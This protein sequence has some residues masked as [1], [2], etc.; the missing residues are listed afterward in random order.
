MSVDDAVIQNI[1]DEE[2]IMYCDKENPTQ[3]YVEYV[4]N[5]GAVV[6]ESI[7]SPYFR[8][9]LGHRYREETGTREKPEIR[10]E[11]DIRTEELIWSGENK[12]TIHKRVAGNLKN[13]VVYFLANDQ[14]SS[15]IVRPDGWKIGRLKNV[16]FIRQPSDEAQ[17]LPQEGGDLLELMRPYVNMND[18]DY[19][20][21][22]LTLVQ[23]FIRT[24]SHFATIL[25]SGKGTGKSTL[26]KI[27]RSLVDPSKAGVSTP[28][29]NEEALIVNLSNNYFVCYDNTAPLSEKVS[30]LLCA[31]ITGSRTTKRILYTTNDQAILNLHNII[32]LNGIS[33]VPAK[34]DLAERSLLFKLKK[35]KSSDRATD[36]SIW[37]NF[38]RDKPLILGA[39]F[40]TLSKAMTVYATLERPEKLHRLADANLEMIC[41]GQ[42]LGLTTEKVQ[43]LIAENNKNLQSEYAQGNMLVEVVMNYL[44]NAKKIDDTASVVY[45]ELRDSIVGD[46]RFFPSAPNA[47]SMKLNE[48]RDALAQAGIRLHRYK[49]S[50]HN[51]ILLEKIPKSQMTKA[52]KS[53]IS[54]EK[55]DFSLES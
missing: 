50:D 52:Q 4:N 54:K 23:Y 55:S 2:V 16:K 13:T 6:F 7:D 27:I 19:L 9:F 15:V 38:K 37:E 1:L 48:E 3:V 17:V 53:S 46:R 18:D 51:Y 20:L 32:V 40:T 44:S 11:L 28:P 8:A 33:I 30:N 24:S 25:S 34:S 43:D 22:I 29:Q 14:W 10:E 45:T 12:V 39:I 41:I 42:A 21:F 36:S 5:K 35:I 26:S 49:K 47:L 31:S